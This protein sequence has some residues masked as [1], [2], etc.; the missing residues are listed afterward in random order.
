MTG[1]YEIWE[2][3]KL[4][5]TLIREFKLWLVAARPK[6][7]T[8]GS[9]L[10][11]LKRAAISPGELTSD[12]AVELVD[13][14]SWYEARIKRVFNCDRFNYVMA[15]MKD[16]YVH[17]HAFPRYAQVVNALGT[18]WTDTDWPQVIQFRDVQTSD[19]VLQKICAAIKE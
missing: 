10:I 5:T 6:Q 14:L 8:L 3:F 12:E 18:E 4:E 11:L 7:V 1:K 9:C 13:V 2:R 17:L 15:M 16:P 19:L